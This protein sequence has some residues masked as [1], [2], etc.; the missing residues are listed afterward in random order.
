MCLKFI[1]QQSKCFDLYELWPMCILVTLPT[2]YS[3]FLGRKYKSQNL[4]VAIVLSPN[5][6]P[7]C[8]VSLKFIQVNLNGKRSSKTCCLSK[9]K[10]V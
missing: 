5:S 3:N 7:I 8:F 2:W 10:V 1:S 9:P 6:N 4:F